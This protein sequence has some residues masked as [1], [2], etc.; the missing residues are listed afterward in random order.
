GWSGTGIQ[1][2]AWHEG[3]AVPLR[4][5]K[6]NGD[7]IGTLIGDDEVRSTVKLSDNDRD[8]IRADEETT[9]AVQRGAE[10][11]PRQTGEDEHAVAAA[12]EDDRIHDSVAT[13]VC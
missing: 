10:A 9:S 7:L 6:Q 2:G 12:V 1:A 4:F 13:Q 11:A 8:R 5:V 3:E